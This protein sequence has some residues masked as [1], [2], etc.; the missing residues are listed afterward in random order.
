MAYNTSFPTIPQNGVPFDLAEMNLLGESGTRR[1]VAVSR[2]CPAVCMAQVGMCEKGCF[3]APGGRKQAP[4][5]GELE[6][7]A[8]DRGSSGPCPPLS[9]KQR[10]GN[11]TSILSHWHLSLKRADRG[12]AKCW[13][14]S[15]SQERRGRWVGEARS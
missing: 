5:K 2:A 9:R 6:R 1:E 14:F 13:I 4:S 10:E 3:P 11:E 15:G 12:A 8:S 7:A